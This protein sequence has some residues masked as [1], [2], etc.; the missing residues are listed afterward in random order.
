M[1]AALP[2][3]IGIFGGSFNPPH[4][5]HVLA[6]QFALAAWPLDRIII[7]PNLV[8]AFGK[9]L[10]SFE[11]RYHM[12]LIA[13][14]HLMPF[15]E[16]SRIEETLGGVSYTI[17]TI[18]ALRHEH[19]GA[20]MNLIVGSDIVAETRKWRNY[21]ALEKEA[22]PLVIPRL[23]FDRPVDPKETHPG[24]TLLPAVSSSWVREQLALGKDTGYALPRLVRE[25]I[26]EHSLYGA[27]ATT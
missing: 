9:P 16:V 19:P 20:H 22:P 15:I 7:V 27:P 6:C 5:S 21:E 23:L 2:R 8:H 17:E 25:Y 12:C 4:M 14:Q 1:A 18:R 24:E 26:R 11:H 10:E 13:F 3:R